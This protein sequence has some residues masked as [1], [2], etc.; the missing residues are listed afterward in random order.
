MSNEFHMREGGEHVSE[1]EPTAAEG[2]EAET[3]PEEAPAATEAG[4][5]EGEE[6]TPE[7]AETGAEEPAPTPAEEAEAEEPAT[8]E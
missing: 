4:P 7:A 8:E 3:T 1:Q 6:P 5:A 2:T